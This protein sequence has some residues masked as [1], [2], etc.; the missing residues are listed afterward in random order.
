MDQNVFQF[1]EVERV[2]KQ[3]GGLTALPRPRGGN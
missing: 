1:L 2:T 3:F